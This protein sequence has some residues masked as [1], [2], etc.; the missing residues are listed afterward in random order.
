MTRS[1]LIAA[2]ASACTGPTSG[3]SGTSPTSASTW[4]GI[5]PMTLVLGSDTIVNDV[6][7]SGGWEVGSDQDPLLV[8]VTEDGELG[9][10]TSDGFAFVNANVRFEDDPAALADDW[11]AGNDVSGVPGI[12]GVLLN[13]DDTS[14]TVGGTA[15][16]CD[17][18]FTWVEAFPP[19]PIQPDTTVHRYTLA[20]DCTDL[21]WE[22]LG[23][24]DA[25]GA[26]ATAS[27]GL[28]VRIAVF[29]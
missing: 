13:S 2:I 20:A 25:T 15:P 28:D 26:F 4:A 14:R 23:A 5:G 27:L 8:I 1:L 18:D 7:A 12:V 21:P 17:V 19:S 29:E 3:T 24:S 22:D 11:V 9:G 10:A 6:Y 16:P